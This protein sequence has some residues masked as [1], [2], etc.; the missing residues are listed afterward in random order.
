MPW[1]VH[2]IPNFRDSMNLT[3]SKCFFL[4][5]KS[6]SKKF[7][8]IFLNQTTKVMFGFTKHRVFCCVSFTKDLVPRGISLRAAEQIAQ[9][10]HLLGDDPLVRDCWRKRKHSNTIYITFLQH[11]NTPISYFI[12]GDLKILEWHTRTCELKLMQRHLS[13]ERLPL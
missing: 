5:N 9:G 1:R 8:V 10:L 7:P 4:R 3:L 11:Y 13:L 6:C 2:R 12:N